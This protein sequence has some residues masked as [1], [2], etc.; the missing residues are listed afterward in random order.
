MR[1]NGAGDDDVGELGC[2]GTRTRQAGGVAMLVCVGR[3]RR[4]KRFTA[5]PAP[6]GS[7]EGGLGGIGLE[8]DRGRGLR[9]GLRIMVLFRVGCVG[10]EVVACEQADFGR[11]AASVDLDL[12]F[13]LS[14]NLLRR[15]ISIALFG[16]ELNG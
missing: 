2:R 8:V 6:E 15:R 5:S 12:A 13:T 14:L 3:A 4:R 9:D 16:E 10:V 1:R 11:M 7:G